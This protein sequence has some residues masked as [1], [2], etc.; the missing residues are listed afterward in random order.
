MIVRVIPT[1]NMINPNK[2]KI[3]SNSIPSLNLLK[4]M[5]EVPSSISTILSSK[6]LLFLLF[7]GLIF[8]LPFYFPSYYNYSAYL[9]KNKL[10]FF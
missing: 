9:I 4:L 8:L 1:I 5:I 6:I 7:L 2:T 3:I 10:L